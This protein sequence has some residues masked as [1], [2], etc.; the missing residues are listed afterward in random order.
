[1]TDEAI[2]NDTPFSGECLKVG[3]RVALCEIEEQVMT[4]HHEE[5]RTGIH[6]T[7]VVKSDH[8]CYG[9]FDDLRPHVGIPF[10][11]LAVNYPLIVLQDILG[12]GGAISVAHQRFV[13]VTDD[14]C[15]QFKKV[16]NSNRSA[17]PEDSQPAP[18]VMQYIQNL[19][20][21]LQAVGTRAVRVTEMNELLISL[22]VESRMA[23]QAQTREKSKARRTAKR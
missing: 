5:H 3:M 20:Q 6:E 21:K 10:T 1:M 12:D 8:R 16:V 15:K 22:L 11:V 18:Q 13:A 2:E 7:D 14:Y 17:E 23:P 19:Q 4:R 9:R